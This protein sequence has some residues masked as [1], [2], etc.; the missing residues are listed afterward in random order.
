MFVKVQDEQD[1]E[2]VDKS[3]KIGTEII[4]IGQGIVEIK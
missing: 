4:E 1:I 2:L 3:Q